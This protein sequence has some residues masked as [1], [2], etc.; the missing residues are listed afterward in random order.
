MPAFL[1]TIVLSPYPGAPLAH[2]T[3]RGLLPVHSDCGR[4]FRRVP[5]VG[6]FVTFTG[7]ILAMENEVPTITIDDLALL[8]QKSA[9]VINVVSVDSDNTVGGMEGEE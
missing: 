5:Q 9:F 4:P 7:A 1:T 6:A 8:P 3:L 2:I